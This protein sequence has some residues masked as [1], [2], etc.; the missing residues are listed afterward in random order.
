LR[1]SAGRA[2]AIVTVRRRRFFGQVF[3]RDMPAAGPYRSEGLAAAWV[4]AK[5]K[6]LELVPSR[7]KFGLLAD[8]V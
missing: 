3:T 5:L 1:D 4:T 6:R 8:I 2:R 7:S